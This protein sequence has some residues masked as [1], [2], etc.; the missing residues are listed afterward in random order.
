MSETP[1][2]AE[3]LARRDVVL[4]FERVLAAGG[5]LIL[6]P[7][8]PYFGIIPG[9]RMAPEI[10]VRCRERPVRLPRA[11]GIHLHCLRSSSSRA[12]SRTPTVG[13]QR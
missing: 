7:A 6:T 3:Y 8:Y 4:Y 9:W 12:R 10:C 11:S 13:V 1:T 5:R 2:A